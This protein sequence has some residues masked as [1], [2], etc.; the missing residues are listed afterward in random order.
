MTTVGLYKSIVLLPKLFLFR[1][2][3]FSFAVNAN[4]FFSCFTAT[5]GQWQKKMLYLM[6]LQV[7]VDNLP[8]VLFQ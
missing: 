8:R 1:Y 3:Y 6:N 2:S 5:A 4:V 7:K